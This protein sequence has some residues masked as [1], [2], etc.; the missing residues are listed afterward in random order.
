L[1]IKVAF[2]DSNNH[3]NA[4]KRKEKIMGKLDLTPQEESELLLILERYL[5]ELEIEMANT[6]STEFRK[7]LKQR[8][9]F[10]KSL[11]KR[12]KG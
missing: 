10:M 4:E 9:V 11:I 8:E 12:L 5:P 6:D 2:C 3:L 1:A 7:S